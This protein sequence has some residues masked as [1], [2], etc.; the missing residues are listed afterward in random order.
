MFNKTWIIYLHV[1]ISFLTFFAFWMESFSV[2]I[3]RDIQRDQDLFCFITISFE[4]C[5]INI[6]SKQAFLKVSKSVFYF[7][8]SEIYFSLCFKSCVYSTKK[9]I[10]QNHKHVYFKLTYLFLRTEYKKMMKLISDRGN[11]K[12]DSIFNF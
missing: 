4:M 6:C 3:N 8:F 5:S 1:K 12:F 7:V 9:D 10:L 11:L 2:Q